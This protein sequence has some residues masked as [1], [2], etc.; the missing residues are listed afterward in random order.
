MIDFGKNNFNS[1][2]RKN[3]SSEVYPN[4]NNGEFNINV[5]SYSEKAFIAIYN[6]LGQLIVKEKVSGTTHEINMKSAVPGAYRLIIFDNNQPV[7][8]TKFIKN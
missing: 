1:S 5:S 3:N 2:S 6:S 4:P 8:R 7:Y